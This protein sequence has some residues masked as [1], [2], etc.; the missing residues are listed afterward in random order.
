VKKETAWGSIWLG[1]GRT[2]FRIWA[3]GV[4]MLGLELEGQKTESLSRDPEGWFET[5]ALAAPGQRYRY[6]LPDG[7][8]CP[9]PAAR[10]LSGGVNGWSVVTDPSAY[11]RKHP[12]GK[13][14]RGARRSSKRFIAGCGA[15]FRG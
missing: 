10:R 13:A 11:V 9:D 5:V 12:P 1:D 8:S 4:E 2:R 6:R 3:P 14:A 7:R 15:D